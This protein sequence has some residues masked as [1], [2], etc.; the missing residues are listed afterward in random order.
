MQRSAKSFLKRKYR[1]PPPPPSLLLPLLQLPRDHLHSSPHL[2][3]PSSV[4]RQR[5]GRASLGDVKTTGRAPRKT[6]QV[7]EKHP[8]RIGI[9]E[10]ATSL[11]SVGVQE[12]SQGGLW[13]LMTASTIKHLFGHLKQ[14]RGECC[15]VKIYTLIQRG[16]L[17][18]TAVL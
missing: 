13:A 17:C 3:F 11:S 18:F 4:A 14:P 1:F 15:R 2:F 12:R 6:L 5:T 16:H 8:E 7:G 9:P 10:K